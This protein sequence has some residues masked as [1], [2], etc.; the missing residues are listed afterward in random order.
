VTRFVREIECARFQQFKIEIAEELSQEKGGGWAPANGYVYEDITASDDVASII[1]K[2]AARYVLTA[3]DTARNLNADELRRAVDAIEACRIMAFF[4][5]GSSVQCVENAV[6]RFMRIGKPC[7]FFRDFSLRQIS[8]ATFGGEVL[9]VGVSN[10]GRTITTVDALKAAREQG[11]MTLC[12][13]SFPDA[14]IVRHADIKLFTPTVT[15]PTGS[16]DYYESMVSK[17]AQLQVIDVLYSCYSIRH[18]DA[19]IEMLRRT[20]KYIATTRY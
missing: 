16:A 3:Q 2:V 6:M 5:L 14:P 9:A 18:F 7:E 15:A 1:D 10:S 8:T 4:A 17:L 11:A 19:A 20:D 12:I 13:T